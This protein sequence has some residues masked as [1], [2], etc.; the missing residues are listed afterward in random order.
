MIFLLEIVKQY[1]TK[2]TILLQLLQT[3][4]HCGD[5]TVTGNDITFG[6]GETI[7]NQTDGDFLFTTDIAAG[8]LVL[9]NNSSNG[10][11]S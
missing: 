2:Q 4:H 1:Q 6:N 7:S 3:Q 5:L 9:K 11:S 8:A 10:A